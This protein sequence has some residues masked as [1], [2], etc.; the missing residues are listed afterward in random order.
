M[1]AVFIISIVTMFFYIILNQNLSQSILNEKFVLFSMPATKLYLF[2][3]RKL[4]KFMVLPV[5][6]KYSIFI[7]TGRGLK[8]LLLL[9]TRPYFS[10]LSKNNNFKWTLANF[11]NLVKA[12]FLVFLMMMIIKVMTD[13]LQKPPQNFDVK[14][15][16]EK[17][18][19]ANGLSIF[20]EIKPSSEVAILATLFLIK[21]WE[22]SFYALVPI[23]LSNIWHW[24]NMLRKSYMVLETV[25]IFTTITMCLVVIHPTIL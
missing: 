19:S 25:I 15:R 2:P 16:K 17:D 9:E 21:D 20:K 14:L 8:H 22:D 10:H 1:C 12:T 24:R 4:I 18:I 11:T 13:I 7:L 6:I 3:Q 5:Q 23:K